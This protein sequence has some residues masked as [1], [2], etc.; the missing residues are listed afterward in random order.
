MDAGKN[1]AIVVIDNPP[2]NALS[3]KVAAE[4]LDCLKEINAVESCRAIV[5]TGAGKKLLRR[6]FH[7]ELAELVSDPASSLPYTE[8]LH[9]L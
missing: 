3:L 1:I 7:K 8:K 2:V 4:L 5:I 9:K 6:C